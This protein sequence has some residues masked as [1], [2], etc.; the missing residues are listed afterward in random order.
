MSNNLLEMLQML[1]K[2]NL[3]QI[4]IYGATSVFGYAFVMGSLWLLVEIFNLQVNASYAITYFFAYV[5]EYVLSVKV[6][7]LTGYTTRSIVRYLAYIA[8][9]YGVN[10]L[11]FYVFTNLFKVEYK[12]AAILVILSLFPFKFLIQKY[13][14]FRSFNE[15]NI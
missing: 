8:L 11:T 9:M 1:N 2:F 15:E 14:V 6:I 10:N 3:R 4:V 5:L 12:M 7:F 13:I